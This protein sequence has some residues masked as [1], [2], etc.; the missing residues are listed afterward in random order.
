MGDEGGGNRGDALV[1]VLKLYWPDRA[2]YTDSLSISQHSGSPI[3]RWRRCLMPET[4]WWL[5]LMTSRLSEKPWR[6]TS[7]SDCY[8]NERICSSFRGKSNFSLKNMSNL[9]QVSDLMGMLPHLYR[10]FQKS[11]FAGFCKKLAEGRRC[12]TPC[13]VLLRKIKWKRSKWKW[14]MFV[15]TCFKLQKRGT[16]SANMCS[17]RLGESWLNT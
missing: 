16:L 1:N 14:K 10:N 6:N 4:T 2:L 17:L 9:S 15:C 8:E 11:H 5:L 13:L 7:R 3:W 12:I